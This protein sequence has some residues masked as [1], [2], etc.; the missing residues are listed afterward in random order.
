MRRE[1]VSAIQNFIE[2]KKQKEGI[3]NEMVRDDVFSVL[4]KECK[5]LYYNLDDSIEGCHR[6]KPMNGK[7]E[8]FV[9]INTSKVVQEQVWTAAH[10]LGHVWEV[11]QFVKK[12]VPSCEESCEA[13][14]GRFAAE[15]LMPETFFHKEVRAKLLE[16]GFE[17]GK[18]SGQKMVKLVTYLMNYFG[19]PYKS[20]IRRFSEVGYIEKEY[21]QTYLTCFERNTALYE[22]LIQENQYTRLEEK[23][24]VYSI[25]NLQSDLEYLEKR[26]AIKEKYLCRVRE[27]F[28]INE[29]E[30][31][32]NDLEF[33]VDE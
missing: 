12:V 1:I 29:S 26:G 9:F 15:F 2:E 33:K 7:M 20:V 31:I 24:P 17:G 21:E 22:R 27:L 8:Q 30:T 10:E 11:D 4:E 14:V 16:L 32:G 6:I 23:K 28:H 3:V 13:L 18:L 25:S 5:V 19:T